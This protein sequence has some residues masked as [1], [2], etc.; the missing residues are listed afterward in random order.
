M[1]IDLEL[2]LI[3]KP[4]SHQHYGFV[5][6]NNLFGPLSHLS[7]FASKA[8]HSLFAP[9]RAHTSL[10]GHSHEERVLLF[11]AIGFERALLEGFG[12]VQEAD[13]VGG[14]EFSI[15]DHELEALD[16]G[17]CIHF[18]CSRID[19]DLHLLDFGQ[20]GCSNLQKRP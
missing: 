4:L 7:A 17:S 20:Y 12:T 16:R 5:A 13:L 8:S 3:D 2:L 6:V 11:D 15:L 19:E 10:D 1:E 9:L 14:D 18:V